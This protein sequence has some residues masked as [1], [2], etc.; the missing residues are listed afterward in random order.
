MN[1]K[2]VDA[3]TIL[4]LRCVSVPMSDA[5]VSALAK[6]LAVYGVLVPSALTDEQVSALG[7]RSGLGQDA[8]SEAVVG[9]EV[10]AALI[11][12]AKGDSD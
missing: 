9:A 2:N 5:A 4:I 11:A 8:R 6:A 3:L 7:T 10:R 1:Q 12:I